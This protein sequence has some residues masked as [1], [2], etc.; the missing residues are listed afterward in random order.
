M[1]IIGNQAD[2]NLVDNLRQKYALQAAGGDGPGMEGLLGQ[3]GLNASIEQQVAKLTGTSGCDSGS[4]SSRPRKTAEDVQVKVCPIC[5]GEGQ[6]YEHYGYRVMQ[7]SC[8]ACDGDGVQTFGN[9]KKPAPDVDRK[10]SVWSSTVRQRIGKLEDQ[11][12]KITQLHDRYSQEVQAHKRSLLDKGMQERENVENLVCQLE[13]HIDS[14]EKTLSSKQE[15][16]KR[17]Q[18]PSTSEDADEAD[19]EE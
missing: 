18:N 12:Q 14:I 13:K 5:K 19:V 17:Y 10:Q 16:L 1:E 2:R 15:K 8:R 4:C 9:V 7:S 3:N 6:I 11:I